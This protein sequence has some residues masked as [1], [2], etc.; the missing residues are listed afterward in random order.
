[1]K[2][3]PLP[4]TILWTGLATGCAAT[5]LAFAKQPALAGGLGLGY[6]I[7]VV[8]IVSLDI[9][10]HAIVGSAAGRP[11]RGVSLSG[12][13][14]LFRLPLIGLGAYSAALLGIGAVCCFLI[15]VALVYSVLIGLTL[16]SS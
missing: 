3:A 9:L 14:L 12:M 1:M 11:S 10:T 8:S 15:G 16:K 13:S 4:R 2:L 7:A 6:G 5:A